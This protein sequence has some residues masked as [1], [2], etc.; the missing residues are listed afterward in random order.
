MLGIPCGDIPYDSFP[1]TLTL[2]PTLALAHGVS[3]V[4][5][6]PR[7]DPYLSRFRRSAVDHPSSMG[8]WSHCA[9]PVPRPPGILA[10]ALLAQT[11][12]FDVKAPKALMGDTAFPRVG[13]M[14]SSER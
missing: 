9:K 5:T 1:G 6:H 8:S 7:F 3:P 11:G 2:A 4:V 14:R 13:T 10:G 12:R